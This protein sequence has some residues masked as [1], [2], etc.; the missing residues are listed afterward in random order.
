MNRRWI[1]VA[2]MVVALIGIANIVILFF[3]VPRWAKSANPP[4]VAAA[5]PVAVTAPAA[6]A[7]AP[8]VPVGAPAVPAAAPATVSQPAAPAAA[9]QPVTAVKTQEPVKVANHLRP[10]PPPI[11]PGMR[12]ERQTLTASGNLRVAYMRDREKG[13]RQ[14]ALQEVKNPSNSAVLT[15]YKKNA[16]AVVSPDDEWVAINTRSGAERGAQLY[17]RVSSA[18]LK[19]E[20]PAELRATGHELQDVVWQSYLQDTHPEGT[21]DR[22]DITVDATNW[23]PD[24]H[25]L[26][27]SV[28]PIATKDDTAPPI[29][30]TCTYDVSTR[31]VE[32]VNDVAEAPP[33]DQPAEA[34]P[35]ESTDAASDQ[36]SA[37][38]ATNEAPQ[39]DESTEMEG[40][41]FPATREQSITVEDVNELE[42]SDIRYAINEMFARHGV[43]F[44]DADLRKTFSQFSWYQPREGVG[45]E[46]VE[47][48]LSDLEKENLSVLRRCRDAKIAASHRS[49]PKAIKGEQVEEESEGHRFLRN[50]LDDVANKINE[51]H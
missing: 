7:T 10:T 12:V 27:V 34:S 6:P 20:V 38:E 36:V 21:P 47:K 14:I 48:E 35:N 49:R 24:S 18:P 15:Q 4:A 39:T 28:A 16:W 26:T 32:P 37:A 17:H 46:D 22:R 9:S 42:L 3:L 31:Q 43:T 25:K 11:Q 33:G 5:I 19:Y 29:P 30:W 2:V 13:I 40:E 50:V 44:H 51:D 8:A 45:F 23:E 1:S 41:K